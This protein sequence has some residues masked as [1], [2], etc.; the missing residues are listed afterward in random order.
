MAYF[1]AHMQKYSSN[2][3][4]LKSHNE[5][6]TKNHSNENIDVSKKSEN[7]DLVNFRDS[8]RS[9]EFEFK[10]LME[11]KYGHRTKNGELRKIRDNQVKFNSFVF[12]ASPE[13]FENKSKGLQIKY[14]EDCK[15]YLETKI[16][17]ENI[18]SA[19][20]HFD[21]TTPHMRLVIVPLTNDGRLSSKEIFNKQFLRELQEDCPQFL[22]SN[23]HKIIRGENSNGL[24]KRISDLEFKKNKAIDIEKKIEISEA[25][26]TSFRNYSEFENAILENRKIKLNFSSE[27]AYKLYESELKLLLKDGSQAQSNQ[28][29]NKH[30]KETNVQLENQ[31][32]NLESSNYKLK[33]KNLELE[34][35]NKRFQKFKEFLKTVYNHFKSTT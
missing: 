23:G 28:I 30:L 21:E 10:K 27:K 32:S 14:F 26:T 15:K 1:V 20:I 8:E 22:K 24:N 19:K 16:S 11:K 12:S 6:D 34:N 17:S 33:Q 9:Y 5:R 18:I 3:G 25:K 35:S 2:L 31:I 4:G 13:F 29:K 7:I